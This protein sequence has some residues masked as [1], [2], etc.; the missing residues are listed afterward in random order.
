MADCL[1]ISS[2]PDSHNIDESAVFCE[3]TLAQQ[4]DA[5]ERIQGDV[6]EMLNRGNSLSQVGR[7]RN[8]QITLKKS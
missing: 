2:V 4:T 1:K 6:L 8:F 5:L 7:M 3:R